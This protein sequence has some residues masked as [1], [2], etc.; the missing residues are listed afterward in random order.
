MMIDGYIE[1]MGGPPICV[2]VVT[3]RDI[4]WRISS[5]YDAS[6]SPPSQLI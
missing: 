6:K 5:V 3:F 1:I 4:E 2:Y